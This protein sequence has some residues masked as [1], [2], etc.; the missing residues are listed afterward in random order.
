[1]AEIIKFVYLMIL[2]VSLFHVLGINGSIKFCKEDSDCANYFCEKPYV[3]KCVHI[4]TCRRLEP[5]VG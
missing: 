1:M 5:L 2:F 3:P 4:C